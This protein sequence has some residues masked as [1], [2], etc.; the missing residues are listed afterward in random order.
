[1]TEGRGE[2]RENEVQVRRIRGLTNDGAMGEK[3]DKTVI[4]MEGG[5]LVFRGIGR[6]RSRRRSA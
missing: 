3:R 1:M 4:P 6:K 5:F 2:K